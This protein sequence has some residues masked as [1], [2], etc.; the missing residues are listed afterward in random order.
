MKLGLVPAG[1][2]YRQIQRRIEALGIDVSHFRGQGWSTGQTGGVSS[3][4]IPF[5]KILVS[6]YSYQS[7][8]LRNRLFAEEIKKRECELC[9]WCQMSKDGRIPLELDHINGIHTDNRLENLRI[10]CPNCHSLQLT[11]RG[12]NKYKNQRGWW[13]R[14]T[15]D[16]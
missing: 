8:K 7:Y 15:R 5:D 1:G 14:Y 9:G 11:H 10:L 13:N 3:K 2:N 4:K 16:T 6:N 12:R